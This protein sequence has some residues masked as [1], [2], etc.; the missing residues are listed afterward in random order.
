MIQWDDC[1]K[2]INADAMPSELE[3][4][5]WSDGRNVR[6]RGGFAERVKG[7]T[8]V[9][10]STSVVP[11]ALFP[12]QTQSTR[13][14]V[15][16]G[17]TAAYVDDGSSRTDITGTAPTA[18]ADNKWTGGTIGGV[19]VCNSQADV[20]MYWGGNTANNLASLTGWT[21][22]HRCKSIRPFGNQLIALNITKNTTE[23]PSLVKWSHVADPGAI[24]TSWDETDA[25]KDAGEQDLAETSDKLVDGLQLNNSFIAY[26]EQSMYEI[27]RTFDARIFAFR[28]LPGDV[29]LISQNCVIDTPVGHVLLTSDRDIVV[30]QGQGTRSIID[31]KLKKWLQRTI[32]STYYAR[33][34]V[35]TNPK[36]SEVWVCFPE[37]GQSTCTLAIIW[38]WREDK[39]SI[40]TLP[41]LTHGAVALVNTSTTETW[42]ADSGAWDDDVT[43]WDEVEYGLGEQRLFVC[44]DSKIGIVDSGGQDFGTNI[45]AYLERTGIHLGAPERLKLMRAVYPRF[46]AS[47]GVSLTVQTGSAMTADNAPNYKPD[48]TFTAGTSQKVDSFSNGRFLAFRLESSGSQ[49]WRLRGLGFDAK[50]GGLF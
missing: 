5:V 39:L 30:H 35:T 4:G 8:Q 7:I 19:F 40:R 21:A 50:P 42:D 20:P 28:R 41:N 31:G 46:S 1:S 12:Y 33:S 9:F 2:G 24:P 26:K 49:P 44:K 23:Y 22:N 29:G 34:F 15:H 11:Y 38:N 43:T 16:L 32:D 48:V 18:T 25:T 14:L 6:F 37:Q 17:L 36:Y 3:D 10:S 47:S 27:T 13:F 45:D